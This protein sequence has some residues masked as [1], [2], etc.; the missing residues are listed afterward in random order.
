MNNNIKN[1]TISYSN[2][3]KS[4]SLI[5]QENKN[6]SGIYRWTNN[7][8]GHCYIGSSA[9]LTKRFIRYFSN[10]FLKREI[11][12]NNS[13]INNSLL[14]YGYSGFQLDI[15]EY[16][17][18]ELLIIREQY[19]IDLLKPELNILKIANSRLGL[20]HSPE[21]LLKFKNRKLSSEALSNLKKAMKGKVP[22]RLAKINHLLATGHITTVV[23]KS[24]NTTKLYNSIREAARDLNVSHVTLLNYMNN[25]NK[26]LKG[27]YLITKNNN[28]KL[29]G[30]YN[31]IGRILT[32]HVS[33]LGS[34]PS[35]SILF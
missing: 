9:N 2:L 29:L 24:N 3:E 20:K 8:T 33:S 19:Y 30:G 1:I 14:K 23:N 16:C 26:L 11:A 27:I 18:P 17:E 25:S 28:N 22:S 34:I 7:V 5:Y 12:R 32:L 31:S 35:I 21:T 6:K 4:K 13:K 10:A 15:L